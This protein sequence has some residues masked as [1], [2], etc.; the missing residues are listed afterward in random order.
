MNIF[1]A[2]IILP[3]RHLRRVPGVAAA[4]LGP[5]L[6]T[7]GGEEARLGAELNTIEEENMELLSVKRDET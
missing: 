2:I 4:S 5:A 7:L 6:Q 3:C 1:S